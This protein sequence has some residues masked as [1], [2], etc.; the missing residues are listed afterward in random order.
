MNR[1]V[2]LASASPTR[3]RLLAAAGIEFRRESV[4]L[5]EEAIKQQYRSEGR[6]TTDCALALAEAKATKVALRWPNAFVIGADQILS[7]AGR[8]FDKPDSVEDA[9]AQLRQL[10][11]IT[12]QLVSAVC[13]VKD[14]VRL[15]DVVNS[16]ELTMRQFSDRFLNAYIDA[17]ATAVLGSVGSYQLEGRGIQLFS[18]IE[19]DYFSILGLPLLDLVSFLRDQGALAV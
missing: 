14:G 6:S 12:H 5:D 1:A 8:W 17:E 7:C 15:W 10:R 18:R 3:R 9:R 16:A 2:I 11:G 19:G 4:L 13:V